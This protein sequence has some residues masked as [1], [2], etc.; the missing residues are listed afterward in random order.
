[1]AEAK[2]TS[3]LFS[4]E[5]LMQEEQRRIVDE[6]AERERGAA[7]ERAR[8][9]EEAE[10]AR[11]AQEQRQLDER[12]Q[13]QEA[14]R[15]AREQAARL[16]AIR[17]AELERARLEAEARARLELAARKQEHESR[18]A[19][20]HAGSRSRLWR[21]V[22]LVSS[23]VALVALM[24]LVW[25]YVNSITP[26][27]RELVLARAELAAQGERHTRELSDVSRRSSQHRERLLAELDQLR[28]ELAAHERPSAPRRH[29][30]P[31]TPR[32]AA[33]PGGPKPPPRR[34][35]TD[36]GDPLNGC[37]PRK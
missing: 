30:A 3:L 20:L 35:C 17:Q 36:D 32:R 12:R 25:L 24:A 9:I 10:R 2:E 28:R 13:Q 27:Q 29:S 37:L 23:A 21:T 7:A 18:L 8:R 33:P 14:E 5:G 6:R 4:L 26:I 11:L 16:E 34:T 1:M 15:A 19:A 31:A 22:A